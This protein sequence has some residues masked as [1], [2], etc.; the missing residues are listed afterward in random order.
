[1]ILLCP[2]WPSIKHS[3]HK[4]VWHALSVQKY[5]FGS[6]CYEQVADRLMASSLSYSITRSANLF[7][8]KADSRFYPCFIRQH[9]HSYF[10]SYFRHDV[11]SKAL[12]LR[13]MLT[14]LSISLKQTEQSPQLPSSCGV[15]ESKLIVSVGISLILEEHY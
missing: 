2:M 6:S 14:S 13:H 4:A 1:M 11:Q 7:L 5:N 9:G 8:T 15:G 12:Q 10:L 3:G